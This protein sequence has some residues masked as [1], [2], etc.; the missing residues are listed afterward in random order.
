MR[1]FEWR[2]LWKQCHAGLLRTVNVGE[3]IE[4]F[5]L[6]SDGNIV[7]MHHVHGFD[8]SG[9]QSFISV[10]DLDTE[11][12]LQRH[13]CGE[14]VGLF[15]DREHSEFCFSSVHGHV[16]R[17][18]THGK[19][20]F[21]QRNPDQTRAAAP[22]PRTNSVL[23]VGDYGQLRVCPRGSNEA[24]VVC[25]LPDGFVCGG[26]AVSDDG[27]WCLLFS[28]G[29]VSEQ[30][31]LRVELPTGKTTWSKN[32]DVEFARM[33]H[34]RPAAFLNAGEV[35]IHSGVRGVV[36]LDCETGDVVGSLERPNASHSSWLRESPGVDFLA[37]LH[38]SRGN[39]T[40][41]DLETKEI[42]ATLPHEQV[43]DAEWVNDDV[44][45][46]SGRDGCLRWWNI[47]L[48]VRGA[49]TKMASLRFVNFWEAASGRDGREILTVSG[50]D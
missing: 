48:A 28:R 45:V 14:V 31:C 16:H 22:L 43:T 8:E 11:Q 30:R 32:Y 40:V 37:A 9:T 21:T 18:P 7:G 4:A 49:R 12:V 6:S 47:P 2:Y 41:W 3:P 42:I 27:T 29:R 38:D 1:G 44:L 23:V 26:L 39:V 50:A 25:D 19:P 24:I 17:F 33:G 13:K 5:T 34:G 46:T 15:Y 10:H 36:T 35:A 20:T